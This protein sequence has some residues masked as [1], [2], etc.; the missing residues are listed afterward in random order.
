MKLVSTT[1]SNFRSITS[2]YKVALND[3]TVLVGPNNEGKS[4]VLAA[5]SIALS[6]LESGRFQ[7]LAKTL[8]Y[9][10]LPNG[11]SYSWER[12]FPIKAQDSQPDGTSDVTLEFSLTA[13]EL[14]NFAKQTSVNLGSNLKIK[15]IF[16]PQSARVELLL[17]G[18]AKAKLKENALSEKTTNAIAQFIASNMMLKYIPAVRTSA[19]AEQVINDMLRQ[20]LSLLED[21]AEFIG[22]VKSIERLQAPILKLLGSELQ[23]TIAG[24]VP[25][26]KA[27]RLSTSQTIARAIRSAA[28][29]SIDDGV[30]TPIQMKGDGIKSLLAIALMK[31]W[32]ESRLGSRSLILAVEE[33]ESHLHPRAIH[34][35]K[36]VLR[37]VAVDS[38]VIL[39]THCAPLVDREIAARNIIVQ[40]GSAKSATSIQQVRDALG[41][42]Q[43]DNLSSA[44]LIL[45][46]E[47]DEDE[48]VLW[49]WLTHRSQKT[50][51]ALSDDDL[52]IDAMGGCTNLEYKAPARCQCMF[53]A[54][55]HRQRRSWSKGL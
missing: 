23:K 50:A 46:V 5:I 10:Y 16:G 40:D 3:F 11:E 7:F 53:I 32:S 33:P 15:V 35:L 41:I 44:R 34:R 52:A 6:L 18:K 27:V 49:S 43:A 48:R 8:R 17:Q 24:F 14:K 26:V 29:V 2:A 4:N 12:D 9:K 42:I 21:N 36:D 31:H 55:L 20:R 37:D 1:I 19:M 38:Q 30:A 25:E 28:E 13:E 39:T 22:H 45:V 54:Y 47:G 51:K